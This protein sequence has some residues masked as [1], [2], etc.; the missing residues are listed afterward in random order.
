MNRAPIQE[1][2][3]VLA[4]TDL[5]AS[6]RGSRTGPHHP[7]CQG[8]AEVL[9]VE[10]KQPRRE[11]ALLGSSHCHCHCRHCPV[12]HGIEPAACAAAGV[13]K[14]AGGRPVSEC[15]GASTCVC[16]GQLRA[17]GCLA[18]LCSHQETRAGASQGAA[19]GGPTSLW[20]IRRERTG[21][22]ASRWWLPLPGCAG[23]S[24]S[25]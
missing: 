20:P 10:R 12:Q 22:V 13:S 21:W 3:E 9:P 11:T 19:H 16:R 14:P 8:Q 24:P 2:R 15:A 17:A 4:V 25:C 18:C 6:I 23:D 1:E 7:H 5:R